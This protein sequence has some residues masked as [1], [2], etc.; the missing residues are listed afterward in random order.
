M[1]ILRHLRKINGSN[2]LSSKKQETTHILINIRMH[3]L[4]IVIYITEY[5]V[6]MKIIN[7]KFQ[8]KKRKEFHT[9]K[10]RKAANHTVYSYGSYLYTLRNRQKSVTGKNQ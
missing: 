8:E 4:I 9:Q 1:L 6:A 5:Y 7:V 3:K 10:M 2:I